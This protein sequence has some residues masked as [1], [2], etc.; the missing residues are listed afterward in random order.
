[1]LNKEIEK[2][3]K[4][5]DNKIQGNPSMNNSDNGNL[6][7]MIQLKNE[8]KQ[9]KENV[10]V[11]S[12]KYKAEMTKN[13]NLRESIAYVDHDYKEKEEKYKKSI[14]E[15]K[16]ENEQLK[17]ELESKSKD[18][19]ILNDAQDT[20]FVLNNE[21]ESLVTEINLLNDKIAFLEEKKSRNDSRK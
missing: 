18:N 10:L 12:Q 19:N 13:K 4:E 17:K 6:E 2:M 15:Y 9:I 1:M 7:E 14:E 8:L 11:L 5:L 3:K 16:A 21:K 20:I